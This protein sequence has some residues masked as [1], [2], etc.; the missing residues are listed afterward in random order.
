MKATIRDTVISLE[1]KNH[2][3]YPQGGQSL[4]L[5]HVSDTHKRIYAK[6]K[7]YNITVLNSTTADGEIELL[8]NQKRVNVNVSSP[9][10]ELLKSMGLDNAL[11]VKVTNLSSPMPGLVIKS[12]VKEGDE[13]K[14][15]E[16][17]MV[18]EAMKMENI[19]KA[20][21]DVTID[22]IN[23]KAGEAVE[24]GAILIEFK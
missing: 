7:V 9:L 6:G 4:E 18:L 22:K 16:P 1:K 2:I 10:D 17:L 12:S 20:T 3:W 21:A 15:G 11:E 19:L 14:K 23:V 24:K 5:V 8:L 13:V